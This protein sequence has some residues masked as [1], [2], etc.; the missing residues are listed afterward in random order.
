MH[1]SSWLRLIA[2]LMIC[3][4]LNTFVSPECLYCCFTLFKINGLDAFLYLQV[5]QTRR[6]LLEPLYHL[7]LQGLNSNMLISPLLYGLYLSKNTCS[8]YLVP[9]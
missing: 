9:G 1:P 7:V 2:K 3:Y 8:G 4:S 5:T 6:F